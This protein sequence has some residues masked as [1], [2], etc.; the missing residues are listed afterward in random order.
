M[1]TQSILDVLNQLNSSI[2]D[3][4]AE[5]SAATTDVDPETS[6][7]VGEL[8]TD[9]AATEGEFA[10]EQ[11][12]N[13]RANTGE[14]GV[15]AADKA[16]PDKKEPH[17]PNQEPLNPTDAAEGAPPEIRPKKT[18]TKGDKDS[19][20]EVMTAKEAADSLVGELDAFL[21]EA[22]TIVPEQPSKVAAEDDEDGNDDDKEDY[23]VVEKTK[24]K[25][26]KNKREGHEYTDDEAK[27]ASEID[28]EDAEALQ[29]LEKWA[30]AEIEKALEA[31]GVKQ[32]SAQDKQTA[33]V[34]YFAHAAERDA[35]GFLLSLDSDTMNQALHGQRPKQ[36]SGRKASGKIDVK[37]IASR[38][39]AKTA[40]QQDYGSPETAGG[41]E[42][43]APAGVPAEG[44][45]AMDQMS[46]EEQV[47][48]VLTALTAGE[49][50]LEEA[51]MALQEL[52]VDEATIEALLAE[53]DPAAGGAAPEM[54][55]EVPA[56]GAP[57]A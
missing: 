15:E 35:N 46:V 18:N 4:S 12:S 7:P 29:T 20:N 51:A 42:A 1:S 25:K 13:S 41:G 22:S 19:G 36:A 31:T 6:H 40:A 3:A 32:A 34:N 5:K 16:V 28:P 27:A 44:D 48:M 56:E 53:V 43:G 54:G 47:E 38:L 33:L 8:G 26:H 17:K 2:K 23:D 52:G 57:V 11:S 45:P 10:S 9:G 30:S 55:G 49:I 37:K 39:K 21:K 24:I 14:I 50:S